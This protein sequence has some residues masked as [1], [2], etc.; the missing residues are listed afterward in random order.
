MKDRINLLPQDFQEA[1]A[2]VQRLKRWLGI[3]CVIGIVTGAS[4]VKQQQHVSRLTKERLLVSQR[5]RSLR[6]KLAESREA[7]RILNDLRTKHDLVSMLEAEL[8]AVQILGV[9]SQSARDPGRRIQVNSLRA[10]EILRDLPVS[11]A[12]AQRS[13]KPKQETVLVV[14]VTGIAQDDLAVTH[15]VTRL[16]QSN[17]FRSVK[18]N[19]T[20]GGHETV[21]VDRH[22]EVQCVY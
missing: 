17:M 7:R 4:L 20:T 19:S 13:T 1:I 5:V 22:Y 3:A 2:S 9:V 15:F 21:A 10:E 16:R 14:T 11:P 18:L 8:P 12:S 6:T